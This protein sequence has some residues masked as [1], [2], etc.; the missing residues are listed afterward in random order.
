VQ[1]ILP[2]LQGSA[3]LI[4]FADDFVIMFA[5]ERDALRVRDVLTKRFARYG[6]SVNKDKTRLIDFRISQIGCVENGKFDFL[7]FTHYWGKSRKG[8]WVLK[9]KTATK[10]LTR[11][12]KA[13]RQWCK[14]NRHDTLENQKRT[15]C[16]KLNGHYSYYGITGNFRCLGIYYFQ[17]IRIWFKEL[18]RRSRK[19]ELKWE[20]F[21]KLLDRYPLSTPKIV[22]SYVT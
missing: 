18:N 22:H 7:G 20:R 15:L 17:T 16:Q 21:N 11:A 2:R 10:R 13:T 6:L 12:I 4:R 1:E 9:R 5:N 19:K 3:K 14:N 8:R